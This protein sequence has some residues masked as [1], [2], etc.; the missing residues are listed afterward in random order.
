MTMRV[1][2]IPLF[3]VAAC[4]GTQWSADDAANCKSLEVQVDE[5]GGMVEVEY[6]VAPS[7]VPATVQAA[8]DRLHP[9]GPFTA[10]EKEWNGGV[11]YYELSRTVQGMEVEA[12]FLPDGT[13]HSEEVQVPAS[14]VPAAVQAGATAAVPGARVTKWEE[15]RDGNRQIVE[16]HAKATKGDQ[17]YK[18]MVHRDGSVRGTVRE[19]PSEIE[20]PV[21]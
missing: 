17:K 4:R 7:V 13:L 8:M 9:G 20:V 14:K 6:H 15:I 10:A 2:L 11:L 21:R 16:Y 5:R 18:I 1:L 12:M 19:V 3:V